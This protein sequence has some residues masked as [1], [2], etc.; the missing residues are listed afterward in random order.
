MNSAVAATAGTGDMSRGKLC[1]VSIRGHKA[2][3]G[4]HNGSNFSVRFDA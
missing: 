4:M 1:P 3:R 2:H